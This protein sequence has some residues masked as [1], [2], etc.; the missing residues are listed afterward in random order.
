MPSSTLFPTIP[1]KFEGHEKEEADG[2]MWAS[3]KEVA[4]ALLGFLAT[5]LTD[6]KTASRL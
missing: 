6:A 5:R 1:A 3:Q 4:L 2:S